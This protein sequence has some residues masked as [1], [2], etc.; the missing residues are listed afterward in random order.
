MSRL[1]TALALLLIGCGGAAQSPAPPVTPTPTPVA[2]AD[3]S[4][5][6]APDFTLTDTDGNAVT[7]SRLLE[8]GPVILAFF[9]K[10]FSGG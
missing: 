6:R 3:P 10:A 2:P 7:L 5:R 1:R 8:S 9:P 4:A